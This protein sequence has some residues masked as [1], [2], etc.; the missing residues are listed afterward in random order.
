MDSNK[1]QKIIMAFFSKSKEKNQTE[2][3]I[4]YSSSSKCERKK[5]GYS[6]WIRL[7]HQIES[8][9]LKCS[10][11]VY[12]DDKTAMRIVDKRLYC[13]QTRLNEMKKNGNIKHQCRIKKKY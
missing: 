6:G 13:I 12:D 11:L 9:G 5:F 8:N 10:K 1:E 3:I 2:I 7:E 4:H